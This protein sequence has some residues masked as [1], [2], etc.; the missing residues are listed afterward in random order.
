MKID[1]RIISNAILADLK[2]QIENLK[3]KEKTIYLSTVLVGDDP[4]SKSYIK[5]KQLK[6]DRLG[7]QTTVYHFNK[8]ASE[9]KIINLIYKLNK[10]HM[11]NGIIIQQP[12]PKHMNKDKI[13][14]AVSAEKDIDG[15]R[16]DSR[17]NPPIALAV[18]KILEYVFSSFHKSKKKYDQKFIKW[19]LKNNILVVG[20]GD[21]GGK[22][23]IDFFNKQ[24]IKTQAINSKTLNKKGLLK[25]ADIII[26][27]V[28]KK[29]IIEPDMIKQGVILIG[30]GLHKERNGRLY[31]DYKEDEIKD[32]TSFYTP[33]PGGIGPINIAMLLKNLVESVSK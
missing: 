19:L 16:K 32:T 17:Y 7:I 27:A 30:V 31:G 10:S 12:L 8:S 14:N 26:S 29:S 15:F 28:G 33:T 4:S 21:T 23:I 3:K 9:Q 24:H 2:N 20:K 25:T 1:G 5:Q 6:A 11:A 22:P 13:I 18:N